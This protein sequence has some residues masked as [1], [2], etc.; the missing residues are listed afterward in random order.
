MPRYAKLAGCGRRRMRGGALPSWLTGIN[1][2]LKSSKIV[3]GVGNALSGVLPGKFGAAAGTIGGLAQQM[4]Y[5]RRRRRG[6]G[7]RLAGAGRR[8]R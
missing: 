6:A 2:F 5:G 8:R 1:D 3:S 4:G 7:L